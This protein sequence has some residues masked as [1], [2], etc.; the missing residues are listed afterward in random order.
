MQLLSDKKYTA[1]LTFVVEDNQQAGGFRFN[2][3]IASQFGFDIGG[4]SS[5]TFSQNNILE[6]L[7]TRGVVEA[8]LMQ[9]RKVNNKDDLLIEHYLHLNKIK[10]SWKT[11]KDFNP[12][13]ISWNINSG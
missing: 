8:T 2:V 7:K 4:S 9:N 6:L 13:F 5:S 10:D 11:N 1:E 12:C 3:R